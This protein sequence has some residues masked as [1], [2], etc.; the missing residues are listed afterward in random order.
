M[1]RISL[2]ISREKT[3][4]LRF[5]WVADREHIRKH[6]G[7]EE[8]LFRKKHL[9]YLIVH[10]SRQLVMKPENMKQGGAGR[11]DK[12]IRAAWARTINCLVDKFFSRQPMRQEDPL[13]DMP[14]GPWKNSSS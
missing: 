5:L 12:N 3:I 4:Y 9:H 8:T 13:S 11:T 10:N 7:A 14:T 1:A 2:A 6:L